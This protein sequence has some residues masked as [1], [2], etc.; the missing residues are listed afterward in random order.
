MFQYTVHMIQGNDTCTTK[1]T[2]E[3]NTPEDAALEAEMKWTGMTIRVL[4]VEL[5]GDC[6]WD[7][8]PCTHP[9]HYCSTCGWHL[10]TEGDCTND[11]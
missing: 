10:A 8:V 7:V 1:T 9:R 3:A 6:C 11:Y 2:V 4:S 5:L